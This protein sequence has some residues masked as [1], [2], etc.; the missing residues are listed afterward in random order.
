MAEQRK[1]LLVNWFLVF[2]ILVL[3]AQVVYA[4]RVHPDVFR[5]WK[6]YRDK[7]ITGYVE[8]RVPT[9]LTTS[10]VE[11]NYVRMDDYKNLAL[12]F[13][14][15]AGSLT[16]FQ[17]RILWSEDA[18]IWFYEGNETV[19]ATLI[20]DDVHEYSYVFAGDI[21]YYKVVP[22]YAMYLKL[23]VKGTG[24]VTGNSCAVYVMGAY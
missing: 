2:C 13:R 19:T 16:S 17:Y 9:I 7:P 8:I 21:N 15:T 5:S 14:L 24:T 10:Y 1:R 20:T 12:M 3:S 23:E 11:T 6:P 22:F 18:V 4:A